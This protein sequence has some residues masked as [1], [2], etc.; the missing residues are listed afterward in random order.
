MIRR[1]QTPQLSVHTDRSREHDMV[2]Q[3]FFVLI[4]LENTIW[5]IE[6]MRTY[7]NLLEIDARRRRN[8]V[9]RSLSRPGQIYMQRLPL[10]S[11]AGRNH[12]T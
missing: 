1:E 11:R 7:V 4:V 12:R 9:Y 8:G 10:R 5:G 6:C 3:M 2:G